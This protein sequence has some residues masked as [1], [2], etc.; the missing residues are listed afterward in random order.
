MCKKE[1]LPVARL[2]LYLPN[3]LR[4]VDQ[5]SGASINDGHKSVRTAAQGHPGL[6]AH[7]RSGAWNTVSQRGKNLYYSETEESGFTNSLFDAAGKEWFYYTSAK[8]SR[9]KAGAFNYQRCSPIFP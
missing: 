7:W 2:F 4:F 1:A 5:L 8:H 3:W 9:H 6:L